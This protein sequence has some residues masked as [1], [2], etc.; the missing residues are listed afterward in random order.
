MWNSSYQKGQGTV[1]LLVSKTWRF[2]LLMLLDNISLIHMNKRLQN[3]YLKLS[4]ISHG[5]N[6]DHFVFSPEYQQLLCLVVLLVRNT[7][8]FSCLSDTKVGSVS[9]LA[10]TSQMSLWLIKKLIVLRLF[11]NTWS[12]HVV[13]SSLKY[14]TNR[15]C[16]VVMLVRNVQF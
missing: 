4:R 13:Y 9:L 7:Q 6:V 15:F 1:I 2:D 3:C 14:N 10:I 12:A 11:L 16:V 5:L 8:D